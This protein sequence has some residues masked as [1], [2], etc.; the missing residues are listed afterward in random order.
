[1]HV[2]KS[3]F[4]DTIVNSLKESKTNLED[5]LIKFNLHI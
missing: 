3:N 2:Y 5:D 1:M 4:E